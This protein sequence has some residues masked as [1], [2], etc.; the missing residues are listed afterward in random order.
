MAVISLIKK[1]VTIMANVTALKTKR[2][3]TPHAVIPDGIVVFSDGRITD[4]GTQSTI[5][6]PPGAEIIDCG[7]NIVAPG[8]LDIH[9]HGCVHG[10]ANDSIEA[11]YTLAEFILRGGTTSFTPTVNSA[12]GTGYVVAAR[13]N[14]Q[15]EGFRGA[16]IVGVH[17]EGP[18]VE[19]KRVPGFDDRDH[20]IPQPDMAM[21]EEILEAGEGQI[22]MMGL[23]ILLP[24]MAEVVR[25]LRAEGIVATIAHTKAT[26]EQFAEAVQ[27]GFNHGTHLYNV[28]TGLHH[29]RPGVLGGLLTY[30]G[31]TTEIICDGMHV[32]PWAIDIAIRCKGPDRLAIITDLSMAGIQDGV[33]ERENGTKIEVKDGIARRYGTTPDMDNTMAGSVFMQNVGVRTVIGLGY[34]MQTAFRMATLT[35]ARIIGVDRY[36]G[37][38]EVGKDADIIIVDDDINVKAAY[39]NGTKLYSA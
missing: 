9:C 17:L 11:N 15:E 39:V 2:L 8:L 37:S 31:M 28:M 5:S 22:K 4:V 30:D 34:P 13:R 29:R 20:L 36:K 19:P 12:A 21:L 14:Q 6:P 23:G 16:D 27:Q 1:G 7:D 33:Y 35:P 18:F 38:L 25:R 32:H 26:A 24:G 3:V 10:R